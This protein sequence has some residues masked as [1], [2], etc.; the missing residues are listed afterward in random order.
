MIY[1]K[2][3]AAM[4]LLASSLSATAQ[5][6]SK[7]VAPKPMTAEAIQKEKQNKL[8]EEMLDNTQ[9]LFVVDSVV[10]DKTQALSTIALTPDL[11]K[12][13]PY[14]SFFHD[15]T[16][17]E[18]YVYVNGFENKCY[19]AETDTTGTSKL[20][21]REKLNSIW[22][23]PQLIKGLGA[24]MKHINYPFMT[25]DGE[26]FFFA[27]KAD[28]GLGGYDIFMT[29]YDP[30]EGKFLQPENVGLPINSHSDDYLYVED[31][32]NSFA[33]FA[34]TRRQP[35]GKVCIYTIK[36]AKNRENYD[37]DN[38]DEKAL[39]QLAQLTHIRD[40]WS[41]P[42]KRNE[43]LKQLKT[44]RISANAATHAAEQTF[45]VN[46]ELAYNNADSFKS[47]ESKQLYAQLLAERDKLNNINKT[48]DE[49]RMSFRK[50]N[51]TSKV[52]LT[53][54]I[55]ANERAQQTAINNIISLTKKIRDI[56]NNQ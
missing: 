20:Y 56:E 8:F 17:P 38:Y 49:L 23:A 37:A 33:W 41:S 40:T 15:K 13:V 44:M 12:I 18:T 2:F 30:D 25:S 32:V 43:A 50:V 34:T 14:N 42:Q 45:I 52:Q 24:D 21:C 26:T 29:R 19:Y 7:K 16:L 9:R 51:G 6:R 22:S 54:T 4:L 5:R 55:M 53:Q 39:K 35:E 11:G 47:E 28:D 48:L 1:I 3:A 10:V 31:D 27:A 36:L 46:D